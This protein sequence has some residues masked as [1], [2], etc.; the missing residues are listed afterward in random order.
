MWSTATLLESGKERYIK[1]IHN[2][3]IFESRFDPAVRR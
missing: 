2:N 1:E 3:N